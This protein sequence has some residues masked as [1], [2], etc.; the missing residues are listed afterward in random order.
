MTRQGCMWMRNDQFVLFLH[1]MIT[2]G[3]GVSR[4]TFMECRIMYNHSQLNIRAK[5][6]RPSFKLDIYSI[7]NSTW[8]L[9]S[10]VDIGGLGGLCYLI[11]P[12]L[13]KRHSVSCVTIHL[14]NLQITRSDIRWLHMV[15]SIFLKRLWGYLWVNVFTSLPLT[16]TTW[17]ISSLWKRVVF[18]WSNDT[19]CQ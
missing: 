12:G 18:V 5:V 7:F 10:L 17:A 16:Q 1:C 14:L 11:T 4:I 6:H 8:G 13:N 3:K 2:L 9:L 15:I 19:W